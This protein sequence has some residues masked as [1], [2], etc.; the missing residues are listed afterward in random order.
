MRLFIKKSNNI[1]SKLQGSASN[2]TSAVTFQLQI[3]SFQ[4]NKF[5]YIY[6]R[7]FFDEQ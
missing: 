7:H 6:D 2:L 4:F 3:R 5:W 1:N